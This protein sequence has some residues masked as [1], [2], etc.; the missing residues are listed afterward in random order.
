VERADA[1]RA[2]AEERGA[3]LI[4][5]SNLRREPGA[6]RVSGSRPD[7]GIDAEDAFRDVRDVHRAPL[8]AVRAGGLPVELGHHG[9]D[10]H[11]FRDAVTVTTMGRCDPVIA[12][13]GGAGPDRH[14]LLADVEVHGAHGHAVFDEPLQT[15]LELANERQS[16]EHP[17]GL[18]TSR[19]HGHTFD[20]SARI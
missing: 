7:D 16:L 10:V 5:L 12:A 13:E 8:S 3:H 20:H 2:L 6:D 15:L 18:F 9:A 11:T 17:P 1:G 4:R 14:C 19:D